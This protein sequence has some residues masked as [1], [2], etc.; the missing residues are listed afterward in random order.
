M[1]VVKTDKNCKECNAMQCRNRQ[2]NQAWNLTCASFQ[3]PLDPQYPRYSLSL[4]TDIVNI[5]ASSEVETVHCYGISKSQKI[6][7]FD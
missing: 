3:I 1:D 5:S 4:P 7:I 2:R 6:N